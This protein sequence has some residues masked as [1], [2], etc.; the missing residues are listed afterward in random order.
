MRLAISGQLLGSTQPLERIIELFSAPDVVAI[1]V[2]P[3]NA[4]N[5]IADAPGPPLWYH[6]RRAV[7]PNARSKP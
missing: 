7:T 2:W 4:A 1:E 3:T 5:G 6:P